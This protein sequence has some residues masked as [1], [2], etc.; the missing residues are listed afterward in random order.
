MKQKDQQNANPGPL[1]YVAP[2]PYDYEFCNGACSPEPGQEFHSN[3]DVREDG[4]QEHL[5]GKPDQAEEN[6]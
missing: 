3:G 4:E 6:G 2:R 5:H 1:E